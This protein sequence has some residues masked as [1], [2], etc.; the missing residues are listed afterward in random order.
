MCG[1]KYE[2]T[3]PLNPYSYRRIDEDKHGDVT[4]EPYPDGH[5]NRSHTAQSEASEIDRIAGN[6]IPSAAC[7]FVTAC[8]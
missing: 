7:A 4:R 5:M 3:R 2:R 8:H 1:L 6:Y